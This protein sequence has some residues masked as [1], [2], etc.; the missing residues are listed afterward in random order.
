MPCRQLRGQTFF[1]TWRQPDC[2]FGELI[3]GVDIEMNGTL[4]PTFNAHVILRVALPIET[5]GAMPVS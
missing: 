2:E 1:Q 3:N 5:S 4:D